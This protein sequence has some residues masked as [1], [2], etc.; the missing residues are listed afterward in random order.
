MHGFISP[1]LE[2]GQ[3]VYQGDR[4]AGDVDDAP[5]SGAGNLGD[6]AG[7]DAGAGR[8]D[9]DEVGGIFQFI[10]YGED[11]AL[12]EEHVFDTVALC[13]GFGISYG[14]GNDFYGYDLFC[15]AGQN[16]PD[17]AGAG[18]QVEDGFVGEIAAGCHGFFVQKFRPFG[19]GL[20]KA[21]GRYA[22]FQT[23]QYF[24]DIGRGYLAGIARSVAAGQN[25]RTLFR[26]TDARA[27]L[28]THAGRRV[29]VVC[30]HT[31]HSV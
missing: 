30:A 7:V 19:I 9:D 6:G 4:I 10:Q 27:L 1:G 20:K 13:V 3:V 5:G 17:G 25:R 21:F 14:F 15:V 28:Q 29:E 16:L 22:K 26:H 31:P 2:C 12:E 11:I 23:V 24:Y 8:V 18:V